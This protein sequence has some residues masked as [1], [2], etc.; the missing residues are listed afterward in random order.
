MK[1][2][3]DYI[4]E[5]RALR[6]LRPNPQY[7]K[8]LDGEQIPNIYQAH[9]SA[10]E[11]ERQLSHARGIVAELYELLAGSVEGPGLGRAREDE[12]A[13]LLL[14]WNAKETPQPETPNS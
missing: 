4:K 10:L 14:L 1:K 11:T 13:G 12:I 8:Q 5:M 6:D 9:M 7:Y 2:T 3:S